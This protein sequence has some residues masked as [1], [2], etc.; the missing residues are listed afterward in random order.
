MVEL[1]HL[2]PEPASLAAHRAIHPTGPWD[3]LPSAPE[4][5]E[6]RHQLNLEQDGLCIYCESPLGQDEGHVEHIRS[7]ALNPP[8]TF[9]YDNLAHSCEGPSHCG[10]C[11]RRQILPIE[12]RAGANQ[13]FALSEITG[14]LSPA[15]GLSAS[16]TQRANETLKILGLN[17]SPGLNRQRRQYAAVVR[18]LSTAAE[19][20][21]FLNT[22]PFRWS[23]RC[24]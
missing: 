4:K 16:D 17:N 1:A 9:I 22:S 5:A 2:L 18:S 10:H 21:A 6:L 14:E 24:L 8:L 15:I 20:A 23:L 12:P 7:K 11:K 13:H 19:I 3:T